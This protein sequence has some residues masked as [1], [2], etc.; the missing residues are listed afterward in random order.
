MTREELA[1]SKL[2]PLNNVEALLSGGFPMMAE[3]G[4]CDESVDINENFNKL[5]AR[6]I[7][8]GGTIKAEKRNYWGHHPHGV[9]DPERLLAFH[10]DARNV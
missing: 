4:T 5:E 6:I 1:V 3:L 8:L 2:N 7:E 9:D 10:C